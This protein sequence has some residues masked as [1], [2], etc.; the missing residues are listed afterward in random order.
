MHKKISSKASNAVAISSKALLEDLRSIIQNARK[1]IAHSVNTTMVML[2]WQTG[3]RISG[4]ILRHKRAEYG[5][6]ILQTVSKQLTLEFGAGY[7]RSSLS[8]MMRFADV[9]PEREI[10]ATLSQQLGWSHFVELIPLKKPLQ[11]DFYAEMCRVERWNVRT[12][13]KKIGGMLYERTALSKKP[14]KVAEIELK[15]LRTEDQLSPDLVFRDPY[16]LDFLGLK[17]THSE[18]DIEAAILRELEQ[19]ILELGSDF[20]FVARQKRVSLENEDYYLDLLFFHRGLRRL[21]AVELKLEEFKPAH[22]GQMELYL[23]WLDRYERKPHE[24]IPLGI[25]LCAEKSDS[26]VELLEMHKS[27]IHVARYLTELPPID[28]LRRKLSDSILRAKARLEVSQK[29]K[30]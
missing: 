8:R 16:F 18:K 30:R 17:A 25:I 14:A 12:L 29:H 22:K 6:Q 23:R 15:K 28:L 9:F 19:F 27:G 7:T 21:I 3:R 10:V 2:Y 26:T 24:N 13:R 4:E 5:E 1:S 20:S 11:R